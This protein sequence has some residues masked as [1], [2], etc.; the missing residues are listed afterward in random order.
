[1]A[2]TFATERSDQPFLILNAR[3][4]APLAPSQAISMD[5]RAVLYLTRNCLLPLANVCQHFFE[6]FC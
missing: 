4:R 1:M 5:L 2:S 6:T 3:N